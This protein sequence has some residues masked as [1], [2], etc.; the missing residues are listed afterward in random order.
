[1]FDFLAGMHF[2]GLHVVYSI[3]VRACV[4]V[5]VLNMSTSRSVVA[6]RLEAADF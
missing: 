5:C 6:L 3:D 2:D 4:C 1:M